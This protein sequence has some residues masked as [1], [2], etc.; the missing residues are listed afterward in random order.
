[1][2]S[3]PFTPNSAHLLEM[4]S[5]AMSKC[6]ADIEQA[7]MKREHI[8]Q[9][10]RLRALDNEAKAKFYASIQHGVIR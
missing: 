10:K 9:K 5:A 1:M 8:R 4:I 7:N 2:T 6:D 3:K